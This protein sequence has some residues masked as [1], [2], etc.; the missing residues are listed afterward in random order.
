MFDE[1][2]KKAADPKSAAQESVS[3]ETLPATPKDDAIRVKALRDGFY[4]NRR[5]D[6]GVDFWIKPE[7]FSEKWMQKI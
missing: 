3:K 7:A 6:E 5:I 1:I 4:G 2:F